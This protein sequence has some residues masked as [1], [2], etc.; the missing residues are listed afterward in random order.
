MNENIPNSLNEA[1]EMNVLEIL[2][3]FW[4][5][6]ILIIICVLVAMALAFVKV[7]YLTDYT[8]SSSGMLYV[9][10]H[11]DVTQ[12]NDDEDIV[13]GSDIDTSR[14]MSTTYLEVLTTRAFYTEVSDAIDGL[15]SWSEIKGMVSIS[16]VN[17]TELLQITVRTGVPE[18]TY[19]IA[20]TVINEAIGMIGEIFEGGEVKIVERPVFPEEP[21]GKGLMRMLAIAF[22]VGLVIG[23]LIA[24]MLDLLDTKIHRSED[25][26]KR[27]NVSILGE[28]SQ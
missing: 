14:M 7:V 15:Y 3:I 27:Y 2:E 5:K 12:T 22:A 28:I 13:Y 1:P 8:Y 18:D 24:F 19:L 6:R 17:E 26:A 11:N 21:D 20:N 9:S 4:S 16:I 10:N 25:V 23:C